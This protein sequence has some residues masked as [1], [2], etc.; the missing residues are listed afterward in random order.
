MISELSHHWWPIRRGVAGAG[1]GGAARRGLPA[2]AH[3]PSRFA[4]A[5]RPLTWLAL[6]IALSVPQGPV[7]GD[8]ELKQKASWTLPDAAQV[9]A[10]LDA[11][12]Q[13]RP[14]DEPARTQVAAIRSSLA[15]A[16]GS[17][18]DWL[19]P[20]A[21]TL[22]LVDERARQLVDFCRTAPDGGAL[23]DFPV[24]S[25]EQQP[26]FLRHNLRLYYARWLAQ[27]HFYDE[28]IDQLQ[29]LTTTDV[30]DPAALLFYQSIAYHRMP[31]KQQ[32][33]PL[34][35]RLLEQQEHL[36]RRYVTVARLVQADIEP[37]E[38]DSLDEVSRLMDEVRRRLALERA[39]TQVRQ[40]E[41]DVIAKL[42]K[43]IKQIEEQQ[44]Q[45]QQAA[46][47]QKLQPGDPA[48]DSM[49]LGGKG[50]GNIDPRQ[51]GSKSGWGNLPPAERQE[52]LQQIGKDLPSHYREVI[53]EYF[54]RLARE[55]SGP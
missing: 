47:A 12:L 1:V 17:P 18:A 39:G 29:G 31:D 28:T 8:E 48:R 54:R 13:T 7:W 9:L 43:L 24:L 37:L 21:A 19:D 55:G 45:Q 49:P 33:L 25:D 6:A 36:P 38:T 3:L 23:P 14:L 35:A 41:Q 27:H 34:V 4:T 10:Q 46:A 53:E 2:A 51:I 26:A 44:Q 32:C 5:V 11:F 20:I 52:A 42:D 40:Q 15:T 16:T 30:V 22:A 50:P